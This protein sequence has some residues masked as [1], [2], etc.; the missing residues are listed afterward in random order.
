M[1]IDGYID[2]AGEQ[3]LILSDQAD[4]DRVDELRAGCDAIL[5]GAGTI[6]ADNP[7]L[8]LRSQAGRAARAE[9]GIPPDPAKVTITGTGDLDPA[10]RFFT[11]GEGDKIVYVAS[12]A[13]DRTSRRL[14]SVA[15]VVPGGDLIDLGWVLDDLTRRGVARL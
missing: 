2:D 13:L 4:L 12:T 3:R 7:R 5:I 14:G 8:V 15:D 11:T 10:A 9:R 1:S 6:R